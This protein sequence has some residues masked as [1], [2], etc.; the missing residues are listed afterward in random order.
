MTNDCIT[1]NKRETI[2]HQFVILEGGAPLA[3]LVGKL[4]YCDFEDTWEWTD[5]TIKEAKALLAKFYKVPHVLTLNE[6]LVILDELEKNG[7]E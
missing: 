3:G 4:F 6:W 7:V 2:L 5:K 1:T